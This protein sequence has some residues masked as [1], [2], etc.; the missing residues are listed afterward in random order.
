MVKQSYRKT[1]RQLDTA[2]KSGRGAPA[3]SRY[4]NRRLGRYLAAAAYQLSLTPNQ[5]TIV[6]GLFSLVGILT[7]AMVPPSVPMGFAVAIS[8]MLGY[9]LD[10]ADGQLARLYGGGSLTGEWLDHIVDSIKIPSLHLAVAVS[11]YRFE[12]DTTAAMLLVPLGFLVVGSV[13]FFAQI[14]N[15][16]LRRGQGL[17]ASSGSNSLLLSLAKVPTDYGLLC[18]VFVLRGWRT[19]FLLIYAALGVASMAYLLLALVKW[20]RDFQRLEAG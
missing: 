18:M 16:Q 7:L 5:V 6:S 14:L 15:E 4:I 11:M 10:S 9:A 12:P 19:D 17:G 1:L 20:F 13:S 3:Y 2:Q 8:L